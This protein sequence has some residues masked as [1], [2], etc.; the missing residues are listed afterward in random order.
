VGANARHHLNIASAARA[1]TVA[2]T[3]IVG[4]TLSGLVLW[5]FCDIPACPL[6]DRYREN[7]GRWTPLVAMAFVGTG[8]RIAHAR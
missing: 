7:S 8:Q 5:P 6:I 3:S 1:S 2:D 4:T